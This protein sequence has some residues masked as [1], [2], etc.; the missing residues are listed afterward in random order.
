MLEGKLKSFYS[1]KFYQS[2]MKIG[3]MTAN[4]LDERA[5][6]KLSESPL[7][8]NFSDMDSYEV[9]GENLLDPLSGASEEVV[10]EEVESNPL[11]L[12]NNILD[13]IQQD[14]LVKM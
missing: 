7:R 14:Q 6:N 12:D 2:S 8:E 1:D 13:I 10:L 5:E 3:K 4:V 9:Y 11:E